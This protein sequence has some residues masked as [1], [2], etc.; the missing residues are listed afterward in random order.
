[1]PRKSEKLTVANTPYDRRVK[2][3]FEQRE[4]IREIRE[5]YGWSYNTL[6]KKYGVSKRTI[7]FV[8]N[9]D[10]EERNRENFKR[11]CKNG[12]YYDRE[13][14]NEAIR[15]LSLYKE[16]LYKGGILKLDKHDNN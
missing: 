8:C 15:N 3:S 13:K 11:L 2:L 14:H 4:E 1:M 5:K 16:K 10:I 7:I 6:A 12:R 9:P